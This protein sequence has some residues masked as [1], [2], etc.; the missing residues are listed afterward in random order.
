MDDVQGCT[1][2]AG[3]MDAG[4]NSGPFDGA[5]LDFGFLYIK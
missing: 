1:N 2:V 4:S 3:G 5:C